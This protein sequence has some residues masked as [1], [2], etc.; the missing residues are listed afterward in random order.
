MKIKLSRKIKCLVTGANGFLGKHL[1]DQLKKKNVNI[2]ITSTK[3]NDL[4]NLDQFEI[5]FKKKKARC[6]F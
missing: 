1:V 5:I 4:R 2:I 3:L 6:C